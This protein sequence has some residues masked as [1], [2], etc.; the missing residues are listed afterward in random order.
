MAFDPEP[1]VRRIR[2]E[3]ARRLLAAAI[4]EA[5]P[6]ELV[7][8]K[9]LRPTHDD[10]GAKFAMI[11][12]LLAIAQR[13]ANEDPA[14]APGVYVADGGAVRRQTLHERNSQPDRVSSLRTV[15]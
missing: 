7:R 6:D 14:V 12:G 1:I 15:G 10:Q 3:A 2:T 8:M 13:L 11:E 4:M 9:M 5:T